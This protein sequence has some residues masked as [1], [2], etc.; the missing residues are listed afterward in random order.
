MI[1]GELLQFVIGPI[2]HRM[3][4]EH[5]RRVSTKRLRLRR[6]GF[7]KL[8]GGDTN[9]RNSIGFEI[10]QVKRTA[11]RAGASDRQSFNNDV[12]FSHDLLP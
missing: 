5:I 2:L 3:R 7:D 9:R 11:R 10:R 4:H 6:G 1:V 12:H 8:R